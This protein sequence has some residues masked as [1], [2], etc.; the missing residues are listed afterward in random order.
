[1]C[2]SCAEL[3]GKI[4]IEHEVREFHTLGE[5]IALARDNPQIISLVDVLSKLPTRDG[6][7]FL[8]YKLNQDSVNDIASDLSVSRQTVW[9]TVLSVKKQF[10]KITGYSTSTTL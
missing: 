9:R 8:R 1:L 7:I 3:T 10:G 6:L 5:S 2:F 4:T